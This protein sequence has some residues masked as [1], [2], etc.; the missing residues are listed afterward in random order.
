[1]FAIGPFTQLVMLGGIH[2]LIKISEVGEVEREKAEKSGEVGRLLGN[3]N[4]QNWGR[5]GLNFMGGMVGLW[6]VLSVGH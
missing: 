2:R 5:V 6:T 4:L 3:W 1:M